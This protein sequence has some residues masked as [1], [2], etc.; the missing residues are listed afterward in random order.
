MEQLDND[1]DIMVNKI[2]NPQWNQWYGSQGKIAVIYESPDNGKTVYSRLFGS[3]PST[4]VLIK[5]EPK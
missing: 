4:R 3:D 5:G 1:I 2:K